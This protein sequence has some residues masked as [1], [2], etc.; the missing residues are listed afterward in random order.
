MSILTWVSAAVLWAELMWLEW[1][2]I[3]R[4]HRVARLGATTL[5]VVALAGLGGAWLETE[6]REEARAAV[7]WTAQ[8][9]GG[10][11]IKSEK[12][13][14]FA[15]P[16]AR[17]APTDAVIV[18]DLA[19]L[20]RTWPGIRALEIR[21]DGVDAEDA[22]LLTGLRVQFQPTGAPTG[23]VAINAPTQM[24]LGEKL[25]VRG[26]VSGVAFGRSVVVTLEA[27]DGAL[28][29]NA[30]VATAKGEVDFD[31]VAASAPATGRFVW[32]LRLAASEAPER[33][34][35][36]E[37][38][39]VAVVAPVLPRVLVLESAPRLDTARL[40]MWFA[41]KGGR[42]VSRTLISRDRYRFGGSGGSVS[43]FGVLDEKLLAGYDIFLAD[44]ATLAALS[45]AERTVLRDAVS[46]HGLGVGLLAD[47]AL[48]TAAQGGAVAST[49]NFFL[50]WRVV[51]VGEGGAVDNGRRVRL[52]GAPGSALPVEPVA[53]AAY[54]IQPAA[55]QEAW[56][57]DGQ[58]RVVAAA[59]RRGR[60]LVALSLVQ[61]TWRWRQGERPAAFAEYWSWLW[62]A[63]AP[64]SARG[65]WALATDRPVADRRVRLRWTGSATDMPEATVS[66]E[67]DA[68][69]MRLALAQDRLEPTRAEGFYW[70]HAAGWHRVTAKDGAALDF[71]V[72]RPAA[73]PGVRAE[74]RR[75]ATV[76]LAA[77]SVTRAPVTAENPA[78][79]RVPPGWILA[80]L[81]ASAGYLWLEGRRRR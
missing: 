63:V 16:D 77:E 65:R 68:R 25:H 73:W 13:L 44:G 59:V 28:L 36:Q 33:V 32:N 67:G 41:E 14:H 4:A 19:Y 57:R 51:A 49:D 62:R 39:G 64:A 80:S 55:G 72:D 8:S 69:M 18:P 54:A 71:W 5:A 52:Q 37:I 70:P 61:D 3:D 66:A 6:K 45:E 35:S 46:E 1:R 42:L 21:G 31:F 40:R 7:L 23:F 58:G 48:L 60:G 24:A 79:W 26:R 2:R 17:G 74:V 78:R 53:V 34:L 29:A 12:I 38:L 9:A 76:R 11:T 22:P 75:Q 43:E 15:L 47:D 30:L 20:R 50:P 10:V 27:P 81:V 56:L